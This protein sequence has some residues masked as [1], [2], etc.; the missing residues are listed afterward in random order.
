[1][2]FGKMSLGKIKVKW[3]LDRLKVNQ[4]STSGL[5]VPG[6]CFLG[7]YKVKMDVKCFVQKQL[8]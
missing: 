4:R 5:K 2:D 6:S 1:M 8:T 7:N 3:S